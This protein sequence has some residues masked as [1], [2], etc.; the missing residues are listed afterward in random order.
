MVKSKGEWYVTSC[1]DF[2]GW[3]IEWITVSDDIEVET[4]TVML[5]N[6]ESKNRRK[7][8]ANKID[9][10]IFSTERKRK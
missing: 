10:P 4:A 2:I 1:L 5:V 9:I 8:T 7:V 3:D 6:K